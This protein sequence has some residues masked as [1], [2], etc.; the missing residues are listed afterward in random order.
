MV[1]AASLTFVVKASWACGGAELVG[2]TAGLSGDL[3]GTYPGSSPAR[4]CSIC[5]FFSFICFTACFALL[6]AVSC[7]SWTDRLNA[8]KGFSLLNQLFGPA[9]KNEYT[10]K[11]TI[12]KMNRRMKVFDMVQLYRQIL[13]FP[14]EMWCR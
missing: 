13:D 2:S 5:R 14:V 7:V 10:T 6:S 3:L 12:R 4:S 1:C 8:A 11:P 9:V